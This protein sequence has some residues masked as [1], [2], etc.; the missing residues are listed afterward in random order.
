[1]RM[2]I[3][4]L[5]SK[6]PWPPK[7]GEAI[8]ILTLSK[9]FFLHGHQVTVLAMNAVADHH[10]GPEEIPEYLAAEI[11][12]HLVDIPAKKDCVLPSEIGYSPICPYVRALPSMTF[13]NRN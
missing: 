10:V 2:K 6:V 1:M 4:Q 13:M 3:L 12:F 9:G 5:A 11:D 8:A 7:D